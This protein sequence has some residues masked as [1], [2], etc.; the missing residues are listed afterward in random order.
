MVILCTVISCNCSYFFQYL[1]NLY[2]ICNKL[3]LL[4]LVKFPRSGIKILLKK[5]LYLHEYMCYSCTNEHK[6]WIKSN[7][8]SLFLLYVCI[9]PHFFGKNGV[10]FGLK[11][12]HAI[13]KIICKN[14]FNFF[15]KF[16]ISSQIYNLLL[17]KFCA[18]YYIIVYNKCIIFW[19]FNST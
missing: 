3:F 18:R 19:T 16:F 2:Y 13:N 17:H 8:Y 12:M 14:F 1:I 9:M 10:K 4:Y 6:F 15:N 5:H 11:Y 7:P